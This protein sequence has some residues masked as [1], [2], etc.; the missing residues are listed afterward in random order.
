MVK[1]CLNRQRVARWRKR[2]TDNGYQ[3]ITVFLDSETLVMLRALQGHFHARRK[4]SQVITVAV[5]ALYKRV[6]KHNR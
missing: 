6:I 5:T 2:L 1:K 3:C 4:R